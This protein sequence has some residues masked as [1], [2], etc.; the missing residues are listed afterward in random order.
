MRRQGK[1]IQSNKARKAKCDFI[2]EKLDEN[3]IIYKI[4]VG[5]NMIFQISNIEIIVSDNNIIIKNGEQETDFKNEMFWEE[6][7]KIL[8]DSPSR[9]NKL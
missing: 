7:D 8:G 2:A 1:L 9:K 4:K 6:L 5:E 3:G